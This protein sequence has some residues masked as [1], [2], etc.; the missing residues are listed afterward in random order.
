MT[1]NSNLRPKP[2]ALSGTVKDSQTGKS[3]KQA[4]VSL[5]VV[6]SASPVE[7][8]TDGSGAF[9]FGLI[10]PG[11]H[12]IRVDAE[13]YMTNTQ[14]VIMSNNTHS[15]NMNITLTRGEYEIGGRVVDDNGEPLRAEVVLLKSGVI[16]KKVFSDDKREGSYSL[17]YLE[18]G[19]YEIQTSALC[20]S[21]RGW[22][23]KVDGGIINADKSNTQTFVTLVDLE[24]PVIEDC[25]VVSKCDVCLQTNKVV[26]YCKFCHAYICDECR[27]NYPERIKAMLRRRFSELRK[28][29][30]KSELE[31]EY[32]KELKE[33]P[34]TSTRNCCPG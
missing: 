17:K 4:V 21:P 11:S 22:I 28:S 6:G 5:T 1:W 10:D 26:R 29:T 7:R 31:V 16:V 15:S 25:V 34:L 2:Q 18:E 14:D 33:T 20:H 12:V 30:S 32:E 8:A 13:G 9:D 24:L 27:H 19:L 23:G 3:I